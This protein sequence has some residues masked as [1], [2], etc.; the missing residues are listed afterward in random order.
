MSKFGKTLFNKKRFGSRGGTVSAP[1]SSGQG[2]ISINTTESLGFDRAKHL[3]RRASFAGSFQAIDDYSVLNINDALDLMFAPISYTQTNPVGVSEAQKPVVRYEWWQISES[4][5][6][7]WYGKNSFFHFIML[8]ATVLGASAKDATAWFNFLHDCVGRS[9]KDTMIA[10]SR[11]HNMGRR[12]NFDDNRVGAP[13]ENYAREV[14]ELFTLSPGETIAPG[15]YTFYTEEDIRQ[16]ARVFTGFSTTTSEVQMNSVG[17]FHDK[18]DKT[19]SSAFGNTTITG[20]DN[21]AL[22]LQDFFDMVFATDRAADYLALRLHRYY[23]GD[24][25]DQSVLDDIAQLL[26]DNNFEFEPVL[27]ALF[28]SEY[29]YLQDNTAQMFMSPIEAIYYCINYFN[30]SIDLDAWINRDQT[31]TPLFN[32]GM[33]FMDPPEIAGWPPYYQEPSL[34][35]LWASAS[36]TQEYALR[37]DQ[38]T[39]VNGVSLIDPIATSTDIDEAIDQVYAYTNTDPVSQYIRDVIRNEMLQGGGPFHWTNATT[40]ER[41]DLLALMLSAIMKSGESKVQ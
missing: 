11:D 14:F 37:M 34:N 21:P 38:I 29:F 30:G 15:N 12:L 10:I 2:L 1:P 33:R 16:A 22:E 23:V 3:I 32:M 40:Q 9:Y 18:G 4:T 28:S 17:I 8:P 19:F 25:A 36:A 7:N 24:V 39:A 35:D 13:N 26:K 41:L 31:D 27:R 20:Q 6:P 5:T